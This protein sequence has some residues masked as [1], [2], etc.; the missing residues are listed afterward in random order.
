PYTGCTNVK[1][2]VYFIPVPNDCFQSITGVL[3]AIHQHY[4]N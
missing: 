3:L 1:L 4:I 2:E